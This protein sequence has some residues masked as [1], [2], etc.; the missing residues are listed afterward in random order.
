LHEPWLSFLRDFDGLLSAPT[1]LHCLGGFVISEGYGLG[2]AT[3]DVDVLEAL[4]IPTVDLI[5]L[6]GRGSDLHK[7]HKVYLDIVTVA[8]IPE[9]YAER[10]TEMSAPGSF[11]NL[12]LRALE[13]HDL[14]LA[15]LVRNSDRDREDL[16]RIASGPGLDPTLLKKR[17]EAELRFQLGNPDR[18]DLTLALW[19]DIIADVNASRRS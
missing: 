18:E 12:R 3:A 17:Y 16:T 19:L 9:N 6:A 15:K 2:R 13:R 14:V 4:G 10:L 1:E 7:R 8:P 11:R 5:R